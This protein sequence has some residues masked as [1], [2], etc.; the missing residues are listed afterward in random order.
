MSSAKSSFDT[1]NT[2][3]VQSS[4]RIIVLDRVLAAYGPETKPAREQ[5]RRSIADG[6]DM[7]WP[8]ERTGMSAVTAIE[9]GNGMDLV[10]DKLR[11][12]RPPSD[13]GRQILAEA[14]HIVGDLRH[15][16]WLLIEQA[17]SQLPFRSSSS[18]CSG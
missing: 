4:A 12:L 14:Q 15:T 11:E 2:A 9:R 18:W 1:T 17:Q 10:R 5:L 13:E 6:I 7:V 8:R 3:V 16:Q